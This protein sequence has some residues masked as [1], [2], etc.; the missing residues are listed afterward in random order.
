ME[1]PDVRVTDF[2]QEAELQAQI[3]NMFACYRADESGRVTG[4]QIKQSVYNDRT[5]SDLRESLKELTS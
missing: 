5:Y 3:W 2:D 4:S 1:F